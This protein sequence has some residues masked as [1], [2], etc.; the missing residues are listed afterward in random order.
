MK[1]KLRAFAKEVSAEMISRLALVTV[2]PESI[3]S[4]GE[5]SESC[6]KQLAALYPNACMT[7]IQESAVDLFFSN[8]LWTQDDLAKLLE[9]CSQLLRR[10]GL[11]MLALLGQESLRELHAHQVFLPAVDARAL[12]NVLMAQGLMH[13]VLDVEYV[14]FHYPD[15][16][17]LCEDL[18]DCGMLQRSHPSWDIIQQQDITQ[19]TIEVIYVHAWGSS[20]F[21]AD[22]TG[23]VKIPLTQL[24]K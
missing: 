24:K 14:V 17:A 3:A 5:E 10:D 11:L 9:K 8:L 20:G 19:V 16:L 13:P 7:S 4:V 21:S 6:R 1:R 22:H 23:V 18:V 2:Q 12:S 15:T